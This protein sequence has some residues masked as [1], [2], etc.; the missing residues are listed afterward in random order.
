MSL[1]KEELED[2]I[3]KLTKDIATL[4]KAIT[5]IEKKRTETIAQLNAFQGAI[6]QCQLFLKEFDNGAESSLELP[7]PDVN[8]NDQQ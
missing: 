4:Q 8:T 3:E 2:Q 5:D 7:Q 6:Q 1:G